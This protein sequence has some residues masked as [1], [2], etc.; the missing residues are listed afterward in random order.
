MK[1]STRSFYEGAVQRTVS[2]VLTSLDTALDLEALARS[3]AISPFH[4]H[5]VFRGILGETP[6]EL[7]RRLR[8]E[9]A[10]AELA[11]GVRPVTEVAFSAG[12]ETHEAF[13]RAFR[14]H[15]GASP[16]EFRSAHAA[17]VSGCARVP[18]VELPA[19]SAVHFRTAA[20]DVPRLVVI[21]GESTMQVTIESM[22]EMRV[23]TLRHIGPYQRISETFARLGE[24][25]GPARLF[26]GPPTMLAIFYDDP[27]VVPAK[28]LRSDAGLVVGESVRLPAGLEERRL[29][30]GRYATFTHRGS[31]E[32]LGDAWARFMGEWL[33]RSGERAASGPS[34]EIYRNHPG[35]VSTEDLRTDLYLPLV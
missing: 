15:Y 20:E 26:E 14:Q 10:A 12:Y 1:A 7:H 5:R 34:Y 19:R 29:S 30:A 24:I 32:G 22:P 16:S 3:A 4:F 31:Y 35:Q 9:R 27:E 33:P 18:Q 23:A 25:V 8:L 6:L 17:T 11:S 28:D 21:E 13:T 2:S